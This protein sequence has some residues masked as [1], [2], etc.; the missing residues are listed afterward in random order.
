MLSIQEL[1][2]NAYKR[3]EKF[4][5]V[6]IERMNGEIK[7]RIPSSQELYEIQGKYKNFYDL[8]SE[9]VYTSCIEPKLNE[10]KLIQYFKCKNNP[11]DIV[12]KIFKFEEKLQ[13]ANIILMEN[14]KNISEVK[15]VDAI[16]N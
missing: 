1:I 9:L 6:K 15:K 2:N 10:E 3:E 5:T 16:K 4:I 12:D 13:I 11:I 14:S 8:A 7:L